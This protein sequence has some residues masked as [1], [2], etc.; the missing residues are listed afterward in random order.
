[1]LHKLEIV[2]L[3]NLPEGCDIAWTMFILEAAPSLKELCITV[4]DHYWCKMV[5]EKNDRRKLANPERG[6][7]EWK[8][9]ASGFKHKNLLKLTIYGFQPDEKMVPYIRLIREV[10]VNMK[11]IW[12]HDKKACERC[13]DLD[14]K[15]KVITRSRV[16]PNNLIVRRMIS[17]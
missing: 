1:V 17:L 8:P 16:Y 13:G 14:P 12:L 10:A 3:D 15:T 4:W 11:E 7:V 2:N 6:N 5:I 9:S